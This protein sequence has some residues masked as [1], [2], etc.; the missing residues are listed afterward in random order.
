[1]A[2]LEIRVVA[3]NSGAAFEVRKGQRLRIAG[4]SIVD[5]VAFNLHDLN[6]RFDQARTKT[7]QVKIF[8][9]TGDVLYSKR[10][11]PMLTIVEDTFKEGR[12]DLQKGMCSRKR[13]EMVAQGT[14]HRVFA[15]GVDINPKKPEE[16]PDHGC[17][18]NLSAAV[19]AWNI[20]PDDVPSPF[21]IFQCMRIDPETGIMYDTMI[22][23]MNEAYVDFRAEIDCLVAVSACPESGR[24]QAIRVEIY[25]E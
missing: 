18:E 16:I 2:V 6:E 15:E 25:K 5:F 19:K 8:I 20:S 23:P 21:N 24:G 7:N 12:H 11:N 17:W 14:A 4:K 9:S 3:K 13:F 22:R 10:N 1:M